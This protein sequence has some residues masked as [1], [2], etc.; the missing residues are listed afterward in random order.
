MT[1]RAVLLLPSIPAVKFRT[2]N[3]K[4]TMMDD[5]MHEYTFKVKVKARS[6]ASRDNPREQE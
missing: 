4:E 2:T 3:R 1:I 6:R 5:D